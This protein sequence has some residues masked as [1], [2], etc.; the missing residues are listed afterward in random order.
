LVLVW[1]EVEP[2]L[3]SFAQHASLDDTIYFTIKAKGKGMKRDEVESV[4]DP[5]VEVKRFN[6]DE[7]SR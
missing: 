3:V 6:N 2:V 1:D 4:S 7:E 5:K